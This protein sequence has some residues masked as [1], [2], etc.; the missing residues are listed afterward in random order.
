M[1]IASGLTIIDLSESAINQN[2]IKIKEYA[3]GYGTVM[4]FE[5]QAVINSLSGKI[6]L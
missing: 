4:F 6:P 5:D 1:P 3:A 2:T